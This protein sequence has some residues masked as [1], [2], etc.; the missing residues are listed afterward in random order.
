[1]SSNIRRSGT[2]S[3]FH[4][5]RQVNEI[6]FIHLPM[7][8]E[9]AVR[10]E[11]SAIRTQTPGNNLPMKMEPT[12]SSETSAIRTQTPGNNLPMKMSP[13]VSSETPGNYPKRRTLNFVIYLGT[14]CIHQRTI[15]HYKKIIYGSLN[16]SE[17]R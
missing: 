16:F 1:M 14:S 7:K 11:T 17:I 10:S 12:V 8:M 4:L 15:K 13:A 2:H 3:R 9:P 5:H 6:Y